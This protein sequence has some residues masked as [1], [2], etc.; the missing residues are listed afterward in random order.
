[1]AVFVA[2]NNFSISNCHEYSSFLERYKQQNSRADLFGALIARTFSSETIS[3]SLADFSLSI[4]SI[5]FDQNSV[6]ADPNE[7]PEIFS[8]HGSVQKDA[9]AIKKE[10]KRVADVADVADVA[11]V[12]FNSDTNVL[13]NES[14]LQ[15]CLLLG[16]LGIESNILYLS[17]LPNHGILGNSSFGVAQTVVLGVVM[18]FREIFIHRLLL[19]SFCSAFHSSAYPLV[20]PSCEA[21]ITAIKLILHI[22]DTSILFI[23]QKYE[24]RE[25]E[26]DLNED[27]MQFW[28]CTASHRQMIFQLVR[29][30]SPPELLYILN[31]SQTKQKSY[32]DVVNI[33]LYISAN[34]H[35]PWEKTLSMYFSAAPWIQYYGTEGPF[36][37]GWAILERLLVYFA[38]NR[39][40]PCVD[41]PL[42]LKI[43][44]YSSRL[45]TASES[46]QQDQRDSTLMDI[47]MC[48]VTMTCQLV[49][50]VSE[51]L[52]Q[53]V[54]SKLYNI[55]LKQQ[56]RTGFFRH[57]PEYLLSMSIE[58]IWDAVDHP[59][60]SIRSNNRQSSMLIEQLLAACVW[61][62]GRIA[63]LHSEEVAVED[64]QP[65]RKVPLSIDAQ[66]KSIRDQ[67]IQPFQ[68][69]VSTLSIPVTEEEEIAWTKVRIKSAAI[70]HVFRKNL[71]VLMNEWATPSCTT[72]NPVVKE[73]SVLDDD[74]SAELL[75]ISTI[76]EEDRSLHIAPLGNAE[77]N[78]QVEQPNAEQLIVE[79][80]EHD[81]KDLKS[82]DSSR[83]LL[84]S[85]YTSPLNIERT[86]ET[87]LVSA[88]KDR[89]TLKY[90]AL[91]NDLERRSAKAVWQV[92]RLKAVNQARRELR[93]LREKEFTLLSKEKAIRRS[94]GERKQGLDTLYE[95]DDDGDGDDNEGREELEL[96]NESQFIIAPEPVPIE[97]EIVEEKS[98]PDVMNPPFLF[99]QRTK[100]ESD[101]A[102]SLIYGTTDTVVSSLVPSVKVAQDPG[103]NSS[104]I[105]SH[106]VELVGAPNVPKL[107]S[108]D[109]EFF[110]AASILDSRSYKSAV[111]DG[112][113]PECLLET[114]DN[115]D[116]AS[117]SS[118]DNKGLVVVVDGNMEGNNDVIRDEEEPLMMVDWN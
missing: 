91:M 86:V 36:C 89:L 94:P 111:S 75:H 47:D 5:Y 18:K 102:K 8:L 60:H 11:E 16:L 62:D 95:L 15:R 66:R 33:G 99:F 70:I 41:I 40:I 7:R 27:F 31:K 72:R 76:S 4:P 29:M 21:F 97:N 69:V 78:V 118:S 32:I 39:T 25:Q 84:T 96:S 23:M 101:S 44:R 63:I 59:H 79:E 10:E 88:A 3:Y 107:F 82:G 1:M 48:L 65:T 55:Q 17:S 42:E 117:V 74:D 115:S 92:K 51:P 90:D 67:L 26:D 61:V 14:E 85:F 77:K 35:R 58:T 43:E 20:S 22:V 49:K 80:D 53:D 28:E 106:E 68:D 109:D 54:C 9:S 110:S 116:V 56:S 57:R 64:E 38:R 34:V 12:D 83:R 50:S 46:H 71:T 30:V 37:N 6:S 81:G 87:Y 108:A 103:G 19:I 93:Q 2:S 105:L 114:G 104:I 98:T 100:A 24:V 113:V 73:K 52:L 45:R 13:M 112:L